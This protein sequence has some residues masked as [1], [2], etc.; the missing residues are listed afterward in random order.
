[1]PSPPKISASDALQKVLKER[2]ITGAGGIID[3]N[4]LMAGA[5]L[6]GVGE[7]ADGAGKIVIFTY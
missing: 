2:P 7:G 5:G 3:I 4:A 1:M 6:G